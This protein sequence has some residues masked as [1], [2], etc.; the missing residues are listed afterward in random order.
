MTKSGKEIQELE[1]GVPYFWRQF[2]T[3]RGRVAADPKCPVRRSALQAYSLTAIGVRIAM[4]PGQHACVRTVVN[5]RRGLVAWQKRS[6]PHCCQAISLTYGRLRAGFPFGPLMGRRRRFVIVVVTQVRGTDIMPAALV[7]D[8]V[9]QVRPAQPD[10]LVE[11][12]LIQL[13]QMLAD[14][15]ATPFGFR[16]RRWREKGIRAYRTIIATVG[17]SP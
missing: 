17:D 5:R 9:D 1:S 10:F 7:A 13:P 11:A 8:D 14:H 15:D 3:F 16:N 12:Q 6:M 4:P 2:A